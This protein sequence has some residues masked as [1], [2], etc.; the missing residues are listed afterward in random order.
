MTFEYTPACAAVGNF[1]G[2]STCQRLVHARFASFMSQYHASV[3]T[4]PCAVGK[5]SAFT[6]LAH[7]RR[8]AMLC[9]PLRM[10][11]SAA[12]LMELIASPPALARP[13]TFALDACAC[14]RKEEKSLVLI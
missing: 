14:R 10:P 4:S 9:P 2:R 11:N 13:I 1:P 7:K 3:R 8:L 5:P 6:S 12:P